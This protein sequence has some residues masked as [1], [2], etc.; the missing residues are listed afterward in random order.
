MDCPY[1]FL[2]TPTPGLT[3]IAGDSAQAHGDGVFHSMTLGIHG[4]GAR[5]GRGAHLGVGDRHGVGA[6]RGDGVLRGVRLGARRGIIL[7]WQI[8]DR[9]A[10][11]RSIRVRDGRVADLL[12]EETLPTIIIVQSVEAFAPEALHPVWDGCLV[13]DLLQDR[14]RTTSDLIIPELS[15][16][17]VNGNT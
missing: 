15:T 16:I 3:T 1:S 6:H 9:M 14:V 11:A 12:E 13:R 5:L 17:M 7:P 8:G 2:H 10:I 4:I